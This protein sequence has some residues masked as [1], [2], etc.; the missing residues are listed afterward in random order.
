LKSSHVTPSVIGGDPN[1]GIRVGSPENLAAAHL[2]LLIKGRIPLKG[3][4]P[5]YR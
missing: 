3:R 5:P 1:P 2:N 4:I